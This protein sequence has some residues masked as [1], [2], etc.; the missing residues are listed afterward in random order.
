MVLNNL[1]EA[2]QKVGRFDEAITA[3]QDAIAIYRE[4]GDQ[5][6]EGN[7]LNNLGGALQQGQGFRV[8]MGLDQQSSKIV[9]RVEML[10]IDSECATQQL[11]SF[12]DIRAIEI[13]SAGKRQRIRTVR[14]QAERFLQL[15]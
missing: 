2:S 9:M 1:G 5:H 15:R 12:G 14:L 8:T 11:L 4:T 6:R 13:D 3:C 10:L 7:A